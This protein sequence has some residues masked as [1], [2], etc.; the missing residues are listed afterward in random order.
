M[1]TPQEKELALS[2]GLAVVAKARGCNFYCVTIRGFSNRTGL[3][4]RKDACFF[5]R[6]RTDTVRRAY[7]W[8]EAQAVARATLSAQIGGLFA[9]AMRGVI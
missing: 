4:T 7:R 5:G 6:N 1:M 8:Q 3:M 9:R 2:G